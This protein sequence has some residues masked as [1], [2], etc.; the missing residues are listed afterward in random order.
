MQHLQF[1]LMQKFLHFLRR[2]P[3]QV[4]SQFQQFQQFLLRQDFLLRL[5][6]QALLHFQLRLQF[7]LRQDFQFL[8]Q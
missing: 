8:L 3:L 7:L 6:L 1:L 2:L 5:P 4:Q